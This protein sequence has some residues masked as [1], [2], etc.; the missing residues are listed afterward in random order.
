MNERLSWEEIEKKYPDE[1]VLIENIER[2]EVGVITAATVTFHSTDKDEVFE[3]P[4]DAKSIGL[5]FT[6]EGNYRN[7][8]SYEELDTI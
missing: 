1:W 3:Y 7:W 4:S 8:R 6:G 5:M 2:N